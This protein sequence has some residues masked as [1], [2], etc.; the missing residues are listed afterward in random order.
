MRAPG[1]YA[2]DRLPL[3]RLQRGTPVLTADDDVFTNHIHADDLA[4]LAVA[5][6]RHGLPNRVYNASDASHL[7][8]GE[9]F[10]LV[11]DRFGLPRPPRMSR[12]DAEKALSPVQLSFM[13]ES[14]RLDNW[15]IGR[16][17]RVRLRYPQVAEGVDAAW[18]E[19]N[20]C[21]LS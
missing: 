11:A 18:R 21:G 15:R 3:E 4:M 14:R 6:L 9:Y 1:I 10:D 17:L 20:T 5:A 2:A 8:M 12:E 19:R 13:S 7:K 16:E